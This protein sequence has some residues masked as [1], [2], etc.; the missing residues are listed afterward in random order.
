MQRLRKLTAGAWLSCI[1]SPKSSLTI[2]HLEPQT[3]QY[4]WRVRCERVR[5]LEHM[6]ALRCLDSGDC[7]H[8]RRGC[9]HYPVSRDLY[10]HYHHFPADGG[11]VP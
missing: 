4:P 2:V 11:Q 10:I 8:N 6:R 3:A 5:G 7:V 1:L 9:H